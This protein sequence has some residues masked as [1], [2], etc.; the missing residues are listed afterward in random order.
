MS[1]KGYKHTKETKEKIR[2]SQLGK[3]NSMYGK[4]LDKEAKEKIRN[5]RLGTRQTEESNKKRRIAGLDKHHTEETKQKLRL[6][7]SGKN[8]AMYGKHHT[9]ETKDKMSIAKSGENHPFY[10]KH[11]TEEAKEKMRFV[12]LHRTKE[13]IKNLFRRRIPTSLEEKFQSIVDKY[14]LPYK[15]VGDG[16]FIIGRYNPDFIN[17]NSEKIAIEVYARY[18]KK[19]NHDSIENWKTKRSEV[20]RQ[21]GWQ[22]IY[23][24]E[25]EVN[26][27]NIL[28]KLNE[29][30]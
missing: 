12:A 19:R 5:A 9:K 17:I 30:K 10:D 15:Y 4:H 16:S 13:Q 11:H 25:I 23:F 6:I 26:K 14:N 18:Y 22:I 20:F 3:N 28:N 2:F 24:D 29:V 8:N 21:Y 7:N 27:E 1:F